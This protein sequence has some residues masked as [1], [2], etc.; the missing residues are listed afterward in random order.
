MSDRPQTNSNFRWRN[1][2]QTA[3]I[4]VVLLLGMVAISAIGIFLVAGHTVAVIEQDAE[5]ERIENSFVE[6]SHS[7]ASATTA[8]ESRFSTSL[9]VG[10]SGALVKSDTGT[11][12]IQG[13]EVNTTISVGEIEY[14][15]DDGTR[16]A[17]QAGGVW[18]ETGNDTHMLSAPPLEY[19]H[20]SET[21]WFP[22]VETVGDEELGSGD[23]TITHTE[24]DPLRN[25]SRIEN[26]SVTVTVTS[27]YYRGWQYYF[28]EVAGDASV[29]DVDHENQTV[30]AR[31][32]YLE[33]EDAFGEGATLSGEY[34]GFDQANVT[35]EVDEGAFPELDD[36]IYEIVDDTNTSKNRDW[37]DG[38]PLVI[39]GSEDLTEHQDIDDTGVFP[40]GTYFAESVNLTDELIF[41]LSNGNATLVVDGDINL[42]SGSIKIANW[43]QENDHSLKI[44][45]TG[46]V[47]VH[48]SDM[49]VKT[50]EEDIDAAQLQLYGTSDTHVKLGTG[51]VLFEGIIYVASD[52]F[53]R[54]DVDYQVEIQSNVRFYG[55]I[56][57]HSMDIHSAA[58]NFQYD[59]DLKE[60]DIELYPDEYEL[61]PRITYLNIAEYKVEV[62]NR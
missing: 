60:S 22:I 30:T 46:D 41:D 8:S 35:A 44:Y 24:T 43:S 1:R 39:D 50:C 31:L 25:A 17:Y 36:V 37:A 14:R 45:T 51:D 6:L 38:G 34:N 53:D 19:D 16:I 18:R 4:G 10:E 48:N 52:D 13:G 12:Q 56:I 5:S 59:E 40:N 47:E 55:S 27:E 49:C 32:G 3:T 23:I 15:G 21:L 54:E 42:D 57:A 20:A 61:P 28:E 33:V 62:K 9:A 29:R 11:I 2:G 58:V 7:M 26:D